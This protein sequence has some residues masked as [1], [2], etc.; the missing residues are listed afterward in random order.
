MTRDS[1]QIPRRRMR[2][3][4]SDEELEKTAEHN[5]SP[6]SRLPRARPTA[7]PI[8]SAGCPVF[9]AGCTHCRG[10]PPRLS[11]RAGSS[12]PSPASSRLW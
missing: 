6:L 1:E 4:L 9:P 2:S 5:P 10:A 11:V 3:I 12:G 7:A 8:A